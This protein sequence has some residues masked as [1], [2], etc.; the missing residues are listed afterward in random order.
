MDHEPIVCQNCGESEFI[1]ETTTSELVRGKFAL[2][3]DAI[4]LLEPRDV[5]PEP[6]GA[7]VSLTCANCLATFCDEDD[8]SEWRV[9]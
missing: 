4:L 9:A 6:G 3:G 7:W 5:Q 8:E 1:E 2:T